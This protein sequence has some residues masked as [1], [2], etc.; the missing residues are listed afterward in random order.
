[1]KIAIL[2]DFVLKKHAVLCGSAPDGFT[3][4]KIN[5]MHDFL[6]SEA[7]GFWA[8]KD[9]VIF[10]NGVSESMLAFVFERLEAE[11]TEQIL[12]YVCTLSPVVDSDKS[13][14]LGGEEIRKSLIEAFCAD[15]C[16]QVI[17][18]CGREMVSDEEME[19]VPILAEK[20]V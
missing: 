9:I 8:E 15:G 20:I 4:K 1:M 3:Q 12:L 7:G 16:G 19:D 6:T 11:K 10:P 17:Y 18:D 2:G 13:V 14:W 5:E